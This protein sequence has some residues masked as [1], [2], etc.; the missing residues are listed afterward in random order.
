MKALL[1]LAAG[2][3]GPDVMILLIMLTGRCRSMNQTIPCC[4]CSRI[5]RLER[6]QGIAT[7]CDAHDRLA[8]M[9]GDDRNCTQWCDVCFAVAGP[10]S[11]PK[12]HRRQHQQQ[13]SVPTGRVSLV[14]S[15]RLRSQYSRVRS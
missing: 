13:R 1:S 10:E 4:D 3:F 12:P 9:A 5:W 8:K 15:K 6:P 2:R 14:L 11:E 7:R